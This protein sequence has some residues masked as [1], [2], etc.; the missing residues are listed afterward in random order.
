LFE[1][2]S[3]IKMLIKRR[4]VYQVLETVS[5]KFEDATNVIESIVIKY[6]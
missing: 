1:Q 3:D 2:E 5:D 4:E 6:A